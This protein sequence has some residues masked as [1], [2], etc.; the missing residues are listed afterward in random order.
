MDSV[1]E[2]NGTRWKIF[3]YRI[4]CILILLIICNIIYDV[5]SEG[6]FSIVMT[7][8]FWVIPTILIASYFF[9][10]NTYKF[11]ITHEAFIAERL[12]FTRINF[13]LDKI[14]KIEKRSWST[15]YK[16]HYV[17]KCC[18]K[19]VILNPYYFRKCGVG[20]DDVMAELQERVDKANEAK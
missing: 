3:C 7:S 10:H 1:I 12:F 20:F 13:P 11:T 6:I 5:L 17:I 15:I 2:E 8:I 9:S 4:T 18:N 16:Y 14:L 19:S